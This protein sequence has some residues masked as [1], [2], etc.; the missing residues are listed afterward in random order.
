M[1][2]SGSD[3]S[4]RTKVEVSKSN[5]PKEIPRPYFCF[6]AMKSVDDS[7]DGKAIEHLIG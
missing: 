7:S 3:F 2:V 5:K 1:D 4:S 6:P